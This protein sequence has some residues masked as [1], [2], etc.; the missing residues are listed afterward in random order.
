VGCNL[1]DDRRIPR[2]DTL[3]LADA[4]FHFP[5]DVSVSS[6]TLRTANVEGTSHALALADAL[7]IPYVVFASSIEAQGLGSDH[8]I[9]LREDMTCRPVSEISLD[10]VE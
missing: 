9:P 1:A 10:V 7:A 6:P 3:D 2:P 8:E 5:A 4:L